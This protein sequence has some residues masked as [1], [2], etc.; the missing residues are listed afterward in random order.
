MHKTDL[1]WIKKYPWG[2]AHMQ[3]QSYKMCIEA[4]KRQGALLKDVRF[5]ELNLTKKKIYNLCL[6]A[7]SQDGLA[8]RFVKWD[9]FSKEQL[10][11]ICMEAIKQ[12]KYAI[13]YVKD[14]EKY[15]NIFNFKY[16]RKQGKAKEVMAI[17]EDGRWRFTIGWQD[18]ITKETFIYRFYK[19]IF[20]D[21]IY[22][23][24]GGFNLEKGI[25]VH[26][27]IYLDFLKEF[28]I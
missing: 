20:I 17:K 25:N 2:L 11:K 10:D 22:N 16:L 4:V 23:T 21:R 9:E 28:E 18:N 7:V 27:Q 19:E 1:E 15:E 26:R 6:I 8:L 14:K 3:K 12:N 24:D 13:K 5:N